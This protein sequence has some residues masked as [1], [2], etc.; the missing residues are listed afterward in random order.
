MK[1][2]CIT[3]IVLFSCFTFMQA[4]KV[5]TAEEAVGIA[6]K[7]NYD[8]L[9]ARTSAEIDKVNNTAGNAGILP[10]IGINGS[11]YFSLNN[12]DQK[13]SSGNKIT[14]SNAHANTVNAGVALG[15]TLFDGGKMFVT[16][17]KLTEIQTLGEIRFRDKVLQ[18]T[19]DVI[20]SYY[21]VVKQNQQLLSY[22]EVIRYNLERVRI[23]QA[24][25]NAGLSP[26]TDLLQA[27]IDLNV[28]QEN[29][30]DQQTVI[31]AAKRV[32]NQLISRD[33]D[34][35]FEVEDSIV[36]RDLPDNKDLEK[37]L[38]KNNTGIQAVQK[39]LE[40]TK[41]SLKE[42]SAL[43]FPTV[44]LSAGY[45]FLQSNNSAS[46]VTSNR[47]YGP[48]LGGTIFIPLFEGG[49]IR[50]QINVGKLQVK[51]AGYSL[52]GIRLD[53][54]AQLQNALTGYANQQRLLKIEKEN[55]ALVKENLEICMDR[56]R[57]GQ[58]T[59]LEVRQAE[60]SFVASHTRLINFEF[61]TKVAETK[62]KQLVSA[63]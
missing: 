19:Y 31:I 30:I 54:T 18:T 49:N 42:Y 14:A 12:V 22:N 51:A 46:T 28:Y 8:I 25:F 6:L 10:E 20:V 39:E 40:V 57:L 15:W 13:L 37:K 38:L 17:R 21:N 35:P 63:L 4:Q 2:F 60:E 36:I 48:Q 24:S 16:K 3:F 61:N 26:K 7:N 52:E 11:D 23:L 50:R 41:L 58:T 5:L 33:I 45:N 44:N 43:R 56:L 47:A 29:A 27:Q 34:T 32:L 9:L 1:K 59:A 62:L 53:V 55:T